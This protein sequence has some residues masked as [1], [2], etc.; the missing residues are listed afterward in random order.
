VADSITVGCRL[1]DASLCHPAMQSPPAQ[2]CAAADN[3]QPRCL[4]MNLGLLMPSVPQIQRSL[5][6]A[7][8]QCVSMKAMHC[9]CL[10]GCQCS[11]KT[12]DSPCDL[13]CA[14]DCMTITT[15]YIVPHG[16]ESSLWV[17][18]CDGSVTIKKGLVTAFPR[19]V[20]ATLPFAQAAGRAAETCG[21]LNWPTLRSRLP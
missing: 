1:L 18:W 12:A 16:Y 15:A 19:L 21:I 5:E 3:R 13:Q 7:C 2:R 20:Q 4:A 11:R 8:A 10:P 9:V 14:Q 17:G 6:C